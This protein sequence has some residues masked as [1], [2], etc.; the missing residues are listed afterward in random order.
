MLYLQIIVIK[1]PTRDELSV[2]KSSL[3]E[4]VKPNSKIIFNELLPI[5]FQ[6]TREILDDEGVQVV[7]TQNFGV[8]RKSLKTMAEQAAVSV[9]DMILY[10]F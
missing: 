2:L 5:R 9:R 6:Y 7:G 1:K 3:G 8:Q 4:H 10:A